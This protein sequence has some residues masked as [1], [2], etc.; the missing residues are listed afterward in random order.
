MS[1]EFTEIKEEKR[2]RGCVISRLFVSYPRDVGN[3]TL[4]LFFKSEAEGFYK[5]ITKTVF[6]EKE[7]EFADYLKN[8]GRRSLFIPTDYKLT[9]EA[10]EICESIINVK[11]VALSAEKNSVTAEKSFSD[12]FNTKTGTLCRKRNTKKIKA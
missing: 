10:T 7:T 1:Y 2:S 6:P 9:I 11:T 5:F 8:G 12:F 3:E 4:N